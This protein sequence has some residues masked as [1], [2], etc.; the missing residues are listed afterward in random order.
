MIV[1]NGT[2]S[3]NRK[4]GAAVTKPKTWDIDSGTEWWA[5]VGGILKRLCTEA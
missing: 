1:D 2:D 4:L 3:E 5:E